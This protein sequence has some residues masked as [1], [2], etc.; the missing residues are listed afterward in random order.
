[1]IDPSVRGDLF[2]NGLEAEGAQKWDGAIDFFRKAFIDAGIKEKAI[3]LFRIGTCFHNQGKLDEAL[4]SY[5]ESLELAKE[6]KDKEGE[7]V[8]LCNIG[9]VYYDKGELDKALSY[10]EQALKIAQDIGNKQ[11]EAKIGR[12]SCRERV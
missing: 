2:R 11:A 4:G 8:N 9:I 7:A 3:I 10:Y 1:M 6:M 5:K 12:A